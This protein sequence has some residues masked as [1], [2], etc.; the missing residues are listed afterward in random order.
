MENKDEPDTLTTQPKFLQGETSP[1]VPP[2]PSAPAAAVDRRAN[3]AAIKTRFENI[4]VTVVYCDE[5]ADDVILEDRISKQ[6]FV[7]HSDAPT[8]IQ[9]RIKTLR[10]YFERLDDGEVT[11]HELESA[12]VIHIRGRLKTRWVTTL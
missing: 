6:Q 11:E 9:Q 10:N 1:V 5:A 4:G 3:V 12:V 2:A 7:E 8:L